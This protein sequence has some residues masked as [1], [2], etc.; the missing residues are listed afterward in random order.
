MITICTVVWFDIL[1]NINI[2]SKLLQSANMQLDV[3]VNLIDK[4]EASRL[5]YR[6]TGFS[7]AQSK[8][9]E[10]CENMNV[11]AVLKQKRLRNTKRQFGHDAADETVTDALKRMEITFFNVVVDTPIQSLEDHFTSPKGVRDKFGVLLSFTDMDDKSLREHCELLG[12]TL[13]DGEETDL[14]W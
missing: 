13:T 3:I 10:V 8:A 6:D 4:T 14:D 12:N 11:E 5:K 1:S 7:D 2:I 9:K